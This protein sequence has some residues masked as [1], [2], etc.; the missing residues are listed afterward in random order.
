M[1]KE[2]PFEGIIVSRSEAVDSFRLAEFV[3]P[4]LKIVK[5]DSQIVPLDNYSK[6]DDEK[7]IVSYL[8]ARKIMKLAGM[9]RL[10]GVGPT[11]IH[12]NTG[13]GLS[14]TKKITLN[15]KYIKPEGKGKYSVP[16]YLLS[17]LSEVFENGIR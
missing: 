13:V 8:L 4:Y 17:S 11:D 1:E 5:E 10:E 16:N 6:L 14:N 9:I 15:S 7:K 2:T 3:R 12:K